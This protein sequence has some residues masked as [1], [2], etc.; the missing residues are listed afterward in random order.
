M[1]ASVR[2]FQHG[3]GFADD[4]VTVDG[5]AA[6]LPSI[7]AGTMSALVTAVDVDVRYRFASS[8]TASVGHLLPIGGN[9][10][11][12]VRDLANIEFISTGASGSLM[13]TYFRRA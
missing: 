1:S 4:V 5:T 3:E 6:G 9:I 12:F 10:E 11:V 7:P 2:S 8:P 13:V